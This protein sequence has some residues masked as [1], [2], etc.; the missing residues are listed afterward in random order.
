MCLFCKTEKKPT[1]VYCV[2]CKYQEEKGM[3]SAIEKRT[4]TSDIMYTKR[5][6]LNKKGVC[7]YYEE[8]RSSSYW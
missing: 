7:Q 1:I 4:Y 5:T 3:C 2:D 8:Y 6:K